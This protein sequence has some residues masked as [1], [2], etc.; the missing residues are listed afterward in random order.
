MEKFRNEIP[1][2][3]G[4]FK[5]WEKDSD[6]DECDSKPNGWFAAQDDSRS[7]KKCNFVFYSHDIIPQS[8]LR[9]MLTPPL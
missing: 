8:E 9:W 5:R 3:N 2:F 7:T 1:S 6:E 4:N